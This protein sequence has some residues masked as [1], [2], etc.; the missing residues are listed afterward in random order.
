MATEALISEQGVRA[1]LSIGPWSAE[2]DMGEFRAWAAHSGFDVLHLGG[3]LSKIMLQDEAD[4]HFTM[5]SWSDSLI[6]N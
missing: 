1:T 6:E 2:V 3:S 4:C 5:L